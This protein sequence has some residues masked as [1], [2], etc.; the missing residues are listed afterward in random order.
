MAIW[1]SGSL[2]SVGSLVLESR[3]RRSRGAGVHGISQLGVR[4][5]QGAPQA[6]LADQLRHVV[7]DHVVAEDLTGALVGNHL[8]E[9]LRLPKR[10][11]LPAGAEG[12]TPGGNLAAALPGLR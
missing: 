10:H 9:A 2:S 5:L 12:E 7:S 4:R 1:T 8:D 6:C 3:S 11:R